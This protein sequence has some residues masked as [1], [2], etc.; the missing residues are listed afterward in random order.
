MGLAICLLRSR[1]PVTV[2]KCAGLSSSFPIRRPAC[3]AEWSMMNKATCSFR[4]PPLLDPGCAPFTFLKILEPT[5]LV[6]STFRYR[7][8]EKRPSKALGSVL[9]YTIQG[10]HGSGDSQVPYST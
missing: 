5:H 2:G 9:L 4:A 8:K 3:P 7:H 6:Y 10:A 1:N